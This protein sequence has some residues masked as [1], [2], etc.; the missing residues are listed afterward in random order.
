M[1]ILTKLLRRLA[2]RSR[3]R[4]PASPHPDTLELRQW[5]DLPAWHPRSDNAPC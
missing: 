5:A 3:V 2:G 4:V 1:S